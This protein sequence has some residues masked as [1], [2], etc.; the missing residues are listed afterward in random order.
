VET[1]RIND[2]VFEALFKQAVIDNFY[3]ELD[4]LPPDEELSKT[5]TFSPEH[6]ARMQRLFARE[7]RRERIQNFAKWSKRVAAVILITVTVL[8]AAMMFVPQVRAVVVETI[9]EWYEKFVSFTS[10]TS[11]TEKT[12]LEPG[13]IPEGFF[14]IL[15]D[16]KETTTTIIF[17]NDEGVMIAYQSF[18]AKGSL[19]VD[20]EK[21]LY[22]VQTINKIEYHIFVSTD[23][24]GENTIV[25]DMDSQRYKIT[26]T[27]S[28][29]ELVVIALSVAE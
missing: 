16:E 25:W 11:E 12:N 2:S 28:V 5:Y 26:S 21:V 14:E 15:R 17:Y 8:F 1:R 24:G 10:S 7:L 3:E 29:A 9:T 4:S 20:N 13:Y 22:E 23:D 27:I 18:R 6:E 19:A